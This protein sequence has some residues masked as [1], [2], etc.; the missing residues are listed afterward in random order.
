MTITFKITRQLFAAVCDDL[1]R[2]HSFAAER[3]G[4]LRC[5]VGNAPDGGL[6]VLAHDYCPVADDQYVRDRSVGAMMGSAAIRAAL[7]L[8]LKGD[9]CVFHVHLHDHNG[10]P[11]FSTTDAR[12]TA[13]FVPD[14]WHVSPNLPHG[15]VIFS[16]D[17]M[18]GRC[19]YPGG[20]AVEITKFV[21]VGAPFVRVG[22]EHG[23]TTG[24][25][26]LSRRK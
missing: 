26:K 4:W 13:K 23:R 5:R 22:A 1:R 16:N 20:A 25:A 9:T 12:E 11:G 8:A 21:I 7:Q 6:L 3:V 14:F 19:W 24:T 15:A 10:Q 18:C 17:S 2:P